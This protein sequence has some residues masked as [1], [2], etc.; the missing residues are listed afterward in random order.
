MKQAIFTRHF[1]H[2]SNKVHFSIFLRQILIL[3]IFKHAILYIAVM[4]IY[5]IYG[6]I[7]GKTLLG[8][9]QLIEAKAWLTLCLSIIV[10]NI[11]LQFN[12]TFITMVFQKT[13]TD[14]SITG[15]LFVAYNCDNGTGFQLFKDHR[16][17]GQSISYLEN[18]QKRNYIH[19]LL[20]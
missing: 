13:N 19:C 16:S 8:Y 10:S 11:T 3:M 1:K 5:Y 17:S 2:L 4:Y 20:P 14:K 6:L 12:V 18:V 7:Q 15:S 9:R